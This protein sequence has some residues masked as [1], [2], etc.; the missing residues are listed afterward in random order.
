[1]TPDFKRIPEYIFYEHIRKMFKIINTAW[2]NRWQSQNPRSFELAL[3]F[4]TEELERTKHLINVYDDPE[5]V[6]YKDK[7]Y[8]VIGSTLIKIDGSWVEGVIYEALYRVRSKNSSVFVRTKSDFESKFK[9][10]S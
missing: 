3:E 6:W 9:P 4:V 1:M 5:I 8:Q 10:K 7:P 2:S